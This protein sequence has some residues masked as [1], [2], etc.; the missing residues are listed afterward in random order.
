MQIAR[1]HLV[2]MPLFEGG[3]VTGGI[4]LSFSLPKK[5]GEGLAW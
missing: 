5:N 3:S 2:P 1:Q 4:T